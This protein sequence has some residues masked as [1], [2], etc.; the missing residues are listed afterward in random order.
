MERKGICVFGGTEN[1]DF[2]F[3]FCRERKVVERERA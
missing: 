3:G 1:I 2:R